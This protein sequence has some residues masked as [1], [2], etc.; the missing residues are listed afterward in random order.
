M[1]QVA[2]VVMLLRNLHPD[3]RW[4]NFWS[5]G[6][7][8]RIKEES[9]LKDVDFIDNLKIRSSYGTQGNDGI[10]GT[11]LYLD[12]YTMVSDGTN[13]SPTLSYRAAPDLTWE[14]SNNFNVG[15]DLGL[16]ER[17]N[18]TADFFIKETKDMI[19]QKPLPSSGGTPTWIWD[20]QIDMKNTGVEVEL[21]VRYYQ[22]A[23]H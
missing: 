3:V 17:I 22:I 20:N 9:F 19:Y 23:Q 11:T 12:Q 13:V 4:G 14:K 8:W 6:G 10:A 2:S 18:L 16:L 5:V 7:S 15:I 21:T 1:Y